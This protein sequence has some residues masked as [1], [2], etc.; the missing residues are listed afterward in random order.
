VAPLICVV[1]CTCDRHVLFG[2]LLAALAPQIIAERGFLVVTDNGREAAQSIVEA[3]RNSVATTYLRIAERGLVAARNAGLGAAMATKADFIAFIDD[4]ETPDERWL[5][6]L[7]ACLRRTPADIVCGPLEPKFEKTPPDWAR[8][9]PFFRKFGNAIGTGNIMFRASII[10]S[11]PSHWF[12]PAFAFIGGEDEELFQRLIAQGARFATANDALVHEC[13]PT[14]RMRL[15]YILN[16]GFRDGVIETALQRQKVGSSTAKASAR[17]SARKLAYAAN[18]LF[19]S[20]KQPW[21][22]VA[23]LRDASE[24]VGTLMSAAGISGRFYGPR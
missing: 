20:W 22:A 8:Q 21:R 18:H 13:V 10:P 19:W 1:V 23:A 9:G 7:A 6:H 2:E 5:A 4:D 11:D 24:A 15:R 14:S 17:H 16:T 3:H 12:Q